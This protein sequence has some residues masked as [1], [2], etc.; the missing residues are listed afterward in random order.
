M[1]LKTA[2]S[3]RWNTSGQKNTRNKKVI[4]KESPFLTPVEERRAKVVFLNVKGDG[5]VG[6][7]RG[8]LV[9]AQTAR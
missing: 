2:I 6:K 1:I 9:S 5:E 7:Q 4:R 3:P 8:F